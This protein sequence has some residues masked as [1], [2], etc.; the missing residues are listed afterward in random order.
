MGMNSPKKRNFAPYDGLIQPG[1]CWGLNMAIRLVDLI[2]SRL[3][4]V[5]S[6]ELRLRIR[7][8]RLE[9]NY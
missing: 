9:D 2:E 1:M 7:T 8:W 3:I 4:A 6:F 5:N